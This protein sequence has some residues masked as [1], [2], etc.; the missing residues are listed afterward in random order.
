MPARRKRSCFCFAVA[1]HASDDELGVVERGAVGMGKT[2][3]ELSAFIDRARRLRR[4]VARNPARKREL[5]EQSL[6]SPLV[7][8]YVR[9]DLAV[10]ALEVGVR[11]Q[12]RTAVAWPGDKDHVEVVLLDDA[13]EMDVDEVEPWRRAPVAEQPWLDVLEPQRLPQ[14]RII[15]EIDLPYREIV[16]STPVGV[17]LSQERRGD[18][19]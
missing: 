12:T 15:V 11:H 3:A 1:N 19:R 18:Q 8:R 4:D 2:V 16:G 6:H 13:I 10:R 9:V 17:H 14:Q 7:L 5:S